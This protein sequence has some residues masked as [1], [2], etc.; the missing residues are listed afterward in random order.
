MPTSDDRHR[1]IRMMGL[2][3]LPLLL[4]IPAVLRAGSGVNPEAKPPSGV[5]TILQGVWITAGTQPNA[6]LGT[7]ILTAGDVNGDGFSDL[8]VGIPGFTNAFAGAGR[9]V[10]HHGS[11]TG[12]G[13]APNWAVEGTQVGMR[14][15][16]SVSTAGDVNGDGYDD[17][18]IG[19][20][21]S[22]APGVAYVYHGSPS[23]LSSTP[24][25]TGTGAHGNDQ[26]GSSVSTAG[27]VNDDGFDDVI[28]GVPRADANL[29]GKVH[30]YFGSAAG[31]S[32]TP[33]WT[34]AGTQAQQDFGRAVASAGDVNADGYAD[35]AIGA[36]STDGTFVN[37]GAVYVHHGAPGGPNA[38]PNWSRLGGQ[39]GAELGAAVSLAGDVNGDG[40]TDLVTGAPLMD[41]SGPDQG[42]V[43]IYYGSASGL[44]VNAVWSRTGPTQSRLGAAVGTAG[45][46]NGDG[47]ADM[48]VGAPFNSNPL[49]A[50]GLALVYLGSFGGLGSIAYWQA[51]GE[52]ANSQFGGAVGTA[53]DVNGDGFSDIVVAAPRYNLGGGGEGRAALWQGNAD[54]LAATE[55]WTTEPNQNSAL[56][57]RTVAFGDW[58]ADGYSD[59]AVGAPFYNGPPGNDSGRVWLYQGRPNGYFTVPDQQLDAGVPEI[60]FGYGLDSAGDVNGDGY[61][62]L[63]VGAYGNE[64]N[65]GRA[66][67]FLGNAGGVALTPAWSVEGAF[68][69]FA[70]SVGTAGDVNGDGFSDVIVGGPDENN[71]LGGAFVYHGSPG[72]LSPNADWTVTGQA[73]GNFGQAVGQ[74]GDVN[75][76]GFSDVIVGEPG[77]NAV[78]NDVGAAFVYLGGANGLATTPSWTI[79]GTQASEALGHAV[80]TA[81]DT[82][83]DGF[84]DVIVGIPFYDAGP[85]MSAG[86]AAAYLGSPA[87]LS[88]APVWQLLGVN[89]G[90]LGYSVATAGDVNGDGRSEILVGEPAYP[91]AQSGQGRAQLF[92]GTPS[93]PSFAASWV[94][95]GTGSDFFFG[96]GLAGAGDANGDGFGDVAIGAPEVDGGHSDEGRAYLFFGNLGDGLPRLPHQRQPSNAAALA[97]LGQAESN[98]LRLL[99]H[100]RTPLGRDDVRLEWEIKRLGVPFNGDNLGTSGIYNTGAPIVGLG[101]R[102]VLNELAGGFEGDLQRWRLRIATGSPF[103][104]RSAWLAL[105]GNNRTELD[106][107]SG[108]TTGVLAGETAP[109]SGRLA[110]EPARPNPFNPS[111]VI[112]F[113]LPDR[114]HAT[115][116]IHDATGRL[117]AR[118][119]DGM[120]DA[121]R[122]IVTWDG[123]GFD[124][125]VLASGTYFYRL[126]SAGEERTGRMSLIK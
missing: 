81:G 56:Y 19:S 8:V 82:N 67:L 59:L 76:D 40:Y 39:T 125:R 30:L 124:G 29:A 63:I 55:S 119:L 66:Y 92:L 15:G 109:A 70:R 78:Q 52:S 24:A 107:R 12:V 86:R 98:A 117:V 53:G 25:W 85:N 65:V 57:G 108:A 100:G 77:H 96:W 104:P 126:T 93:G 105:A 13:P 11:A 123:R 73:G 42:V 79:T 113:S 48:I 45:D 34:R 111:T 35:I 122:H 10:V 31:V 60:A 64:I 114:G 87:G 21:Q 49:T 83:G 118:P 90:W 41:V 95:Q 115:L 46:V 16:H 75:G 68:P 47:Y 101:S 9:V 2:A 88:T 7:S 26:F 4:T 28:I 97:L 54:G 32:A 80:R 72:G 112:A 106:L 17:L 43:S 18:I 22:A 120:L 91:N 38:A 69:G 71:N 14:L 20:Q 74:A 6:N 62:D 121:G 94:R 1:S 44:L 89:T 51:E 84:A 27:D 99:A 50:E 23:G 110:L 5:E 58:N 33:G 103:F 3:V 37:E 61:E 36:P 102:V 116:A